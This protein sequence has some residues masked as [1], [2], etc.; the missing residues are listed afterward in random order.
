[1]A[2]CKGFEPLTFWF[3]DIKIS[4]SI[5]LKYFEICCISTDLSIELIVSFSTTIN[6]FAKLLHQSCTKIELI[7]YAFMSTFVKFY[8]LRCLNDIC[9]KS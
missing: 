8:K 2:R 3:V 5:V 1:M 9:R 4:F 6:L 7:I